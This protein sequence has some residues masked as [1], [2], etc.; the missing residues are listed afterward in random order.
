VRKTYEA[1]GREVEAA[2]ASDDERF[3]EVRKRMLAAEDG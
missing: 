3:A 1:V 2:R